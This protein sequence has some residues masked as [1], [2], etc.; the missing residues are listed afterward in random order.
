MTKV[1]P[2]R[3]KACAPVPATRANVERLRSYGYAIVEP[4]FGPLASGQ[5]GRGRLA[6]L[7]L[8]DAFDR[9]TRKR[10]DRYDLALSGGEDYELL[11]TCEPAAAAGLAAGLL[12]ATGTPLTVIGEIAAGEPLITWVGAGGSPV[13]IRAG[14]EHFRG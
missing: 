10:K 5:V 12:A 13:R 7:P 11:L 6:E 3:Q 14:Y 9:A 1:K 4:G 2:N 8:S